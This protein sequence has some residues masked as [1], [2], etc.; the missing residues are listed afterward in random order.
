LGT[1]HWENEGKYRM[2]V[3][4]IKA[5]QKGP[6]ARRPEKIEVRKL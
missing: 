6:D 4:S 5:D 1:G 3:T 2:E